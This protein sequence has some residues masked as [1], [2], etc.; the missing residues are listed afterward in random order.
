MPESSATASSPVSAARAR[1]LISAF[2]SKVVPVSSTPVSRASTSTSAPEDRL[3]L[4][5]LVGVAR[6]EEQPHH[7]RG[8][9]AR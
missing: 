2:S 9:A 6:G 1:A 4:L 7:A 3:H 5:D 8:R